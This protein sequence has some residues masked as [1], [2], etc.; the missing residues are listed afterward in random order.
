MI[1]SVGLDLVDLE[2]LRQVLERHPQRF[3]AR[4]FTEGERAYVARQSDP[5]PS[6]AARFAAKEAFQKTWP[7]R[8]G[9]HD[10]EVEHDA[11]G[12]PRLA[13][14]PALLAR[15]QVDGYVAHLSL[16]HT[17]THAAAVVVLERR[18]E[19]DASGHG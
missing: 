10:A 13:F 19:A 9:W 6:L 12:A 16:T 1:A 5:V 15:M 7:Q 2:R 11:K 18:S 17:R 8:L 3:L 4:C 14:S